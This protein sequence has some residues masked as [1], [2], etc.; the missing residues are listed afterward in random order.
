M[1]TSF[2][3]IAAASTLVVLMAALAGSPVS[4]APTFTVINAGS[5]NGYEPGVDRLADGT[6]FVNSPQGGSGTQS[7][8][9]RKAPSA[10]GFTKVVFPQPYNR[11]P[12]G[13]D[14]DVAVKGNRVYMLDLWVG[15]NAVIRSDDAGLTW[16]AG[17][18]LSTVPSDREWIEVGKTDANGEDTVFALSALIA[19]PSTAFLA[20]SRDSGDTWTEQTPVPLPSPKSG[21]SGQLLADDTGFVGFPY[22]EGS[23]M[24]F[25]GSPNEG[26]TWY[27]RK[28]SYFGDAFGGHIQGAAL[29]GNTIH[30]VYTA[31]VGY[32]VGVRYA[33][34]TDKGLTWFGG[35]VTKQFS[36]SAVPTD[37]A[38][39][40]SSMFPWVAASGSKVAAT[41]YQAYTS[42][43]GPLLSTPTD[44]NLVSAGAQWRI[45]YAESLDGGATWTTPVAAD[46]A[47][48][49][50]G[51]ICTKG[52][53]CT[54]GRQLGDF[55]QV[56][57][58]G[59]GKAVIIYARGGTARLATQS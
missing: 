33:R 27:V 10:A 9:W 44:P 18:P 51:P 23:Q 39:A 53:S 20:I 30:V 12:G 49:Q 34:S 47:I 48:A 22:I 7:G 11:Y 25:A 28:V 38:S 14:N 36:G 13:F 56:I 55:Q 8:L 15:S 59:A 46:P 43:T 26:K 54:G 57:I 1:R 41:W 21:Y 24:K 35:D 4:A 3:R 16:T 17:T 58:N 50:V 42:K 40:G 31:S 29:V 52:I 6:L 2:V 45:M 19:P 37:L 32:G 5:A